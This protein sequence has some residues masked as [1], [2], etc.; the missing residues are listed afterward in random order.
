MT[1]DNDLVAKITDLDAADFE[2]LAEVDEEPD[3]VP[4]MR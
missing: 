4:V 2:L 1:L 3:V